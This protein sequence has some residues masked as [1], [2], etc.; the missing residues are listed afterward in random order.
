MHCCAQGGA[1]ETGT[2]LAEDHVVPIIKG[3]KA[4]KDLVAPFGTTGW[5]LHIVCNE[6]I[7]EVGVPCAAMQ[8]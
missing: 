8:V 6:K 3:L 2:G 5:L 1:T 4:L 7:K